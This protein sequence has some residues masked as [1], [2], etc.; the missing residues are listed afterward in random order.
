[1]NRYKA[2]VILIVVTIGYL[3][4]V[5]FKTTFIGGLI[6]SGFGAAMIGG[7]ADWY[8][9]TALFRKPLGISYRTEIIPKNREK[10][11]D[12]LSSMVSEELLTKK[13]LKELLKEYDTS[14][15]IIKFASN[16]N[17]NQDFKELLH[18]ISEEGLINLNS[19]EIGKISSELVINNVSQLD[20]WKVI[21]SVIGISVN[22]GYDDKVINF[23]IDEIIVFSKTEGFRNILIGLIDDTKESYENGMARRAVANTLILEMI[24]KLSSE[25]IAD[26]VQEKIEDYLISI[27]DLENED[28][29]KLK[30][31]IYNKIDE[32]RQNQ[33]IKETIENWKMSQVNNMNIQQL[34]SDFIE[35]LKAKD[36]NED[37]ITKRILDEINQLINEFNNNKEMQNKVDYYIKKA[38]NTVID[39]AHENLGK[40]VRGNLEKYSDDMVVDLIE[41]KAG[42]DLQLIRINGSLVG[43]LVGILFFILTYWI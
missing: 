8:G 19:E 1:M 27:K 11:F 36:L 23:A 31:W 9:I 5:P 38:L 37:S 41:S 15:L 3:I 2:T 34:V 26:V 22:N 13:Y 42:D 35:K 6:S 32:I 20:L 25:K 24:M 4:S 10:I 39:S 17:E 21:T 7:F 43:G 28:R 33:N 14:K 16:T 40:L 29:N 12:G 18:L 30:Q